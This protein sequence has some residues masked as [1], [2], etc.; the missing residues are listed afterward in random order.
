MSH[1]RTPQSG[2]HD[3]MHHQSTFNF[4]RGDA[5]ASASRTAARRGPT[6]R[7]P[8]SGCARIKV[9]TAA[10]GSVVPS[11]S[12]AASS[13]PRQCFSFCASAS[14]CVLIFLLVLNLRRTRAL[15]GCTQ[16]GCTLH[17]ME[18]QHSVVAEESMHCR[19]AALAPVNNVMLHVY[20]SIAH[21]LCVLPT[22]GLSSI[23]T[24]FKASIIPA[25]GSLISAVRQ[26]T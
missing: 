1:L 10:E 14:W 6:G 5:T 23:H 22:C 13:R 16:Q 12:P 9:C 15:Q 2:R 8:Y 4:G 21:L 11:T 7:R 3:P 19:N 18:V 17:C 20:K 25:R 24:S 26:P